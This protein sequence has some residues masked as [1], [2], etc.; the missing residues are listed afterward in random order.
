MLEVGN[1]CW[2]SVPIHFVPAHFHSWFL[3]SPQPFYVRAH[4]SSINSSF[5]IWSKR[6][7]LFL[8]LT[9]LLFGC[10]LPHRHSI[11]NGNRQMKQFSNTLQ[12][13]R[14]FRVASFSW[15]GYMKWFTKFRTSVIY[16]SF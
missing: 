16:T 14:N 3:Q 11:S 13:L 12:S 7:N 15:S 10:R 1:I 9:D 5:A 8:N 4:I 2:V 6:E